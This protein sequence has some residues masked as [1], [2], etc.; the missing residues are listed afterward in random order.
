MIVKEKAQN[1]RILIALKS[2]DE[3]TDEELANLIIPD[4]QF[5]DD[6]INYQVRYN[7]KG[8]LLGV[9]VYEIKESKEDAGI[10]MVNSMQL[11]FGNKHSKAYQSAKKRAGVTNKQ[12]NVARLVIKRG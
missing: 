9:S 3:L 1:G 4:G 2:Y 5:K 7:K 10:D 11:L 6:Y 12:V 8:K